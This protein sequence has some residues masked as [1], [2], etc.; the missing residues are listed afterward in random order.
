MQCDLPRR[1]LVARHFIENIGEKS[2][3]SRNNPFCCFC[4]SFLS[5]LNCG[6]KMWLVLQRF[7]AICLMNQFLSASAKWFS[8][9]HSPPPFYPITDA[10]S[11]SG[12]WV[13]AVISDPIQTRNQSSRPPKTGRCLTAQD[14]FHF[15]SDLID[16]SLF[17]SPSSPIHL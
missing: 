4:Y 5:I 14:C 12:F 6:Q 2:L 1:S 9:L 17:S 3:T 11:L 13:L 8:N 10:Y 16:A 7:F 15:I